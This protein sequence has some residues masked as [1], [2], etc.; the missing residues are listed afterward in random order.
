M[1]SYFS[2]GKAANFFIFLLG[3]GWEDI[4]GLEPNGAVWKGYSETPQTSH[5]LCSLTG[6]SLL[7]GATTVFSLLMLMCCALP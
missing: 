1:M 2:I 6:T 3:N 4:H 7:R 5:R